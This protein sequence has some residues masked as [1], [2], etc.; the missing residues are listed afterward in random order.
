MA[1]KR[2][3]K[4]AKAIQTMYDELT[5]ESEKSTVDP[6]QTELEK[7]QRQLE[8]T[9]ARINLKKRE[10]SGNHFEISK[11]FRTPETS[12]SNERFDRITALFYDSLMSEYEVKDLKKFFIGELE[13]KTL[14]A[15]LAR[16]PAPKAVKR[17][18]GDIEI[19]KDMY[20]RVSFQIFRPYDCEDAKVR[21]LTKDQLSSLVTSRYH[22]AVDVD[23]HGIELDSKGNPLEVNPKKSARK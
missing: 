11:A 13:K 14:E 17:I 5:W 18:T 6:A 4:E 3:T 19:E 16:K 8:L 7:L 23:G 12:V 1:K 10:L 9:Q 2:L 22:I 21:T 15:K 20:V